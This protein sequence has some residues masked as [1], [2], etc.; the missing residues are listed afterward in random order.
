MESSAESEQPLVDETEGLKYK[1]SSKTLFEKFL[2]KS[3]LI[4]LL[5]VV[6]SLLAAFVLVIVATLDILAITYNAVKYYAASSELKMY[7]SIVPDII[8][9]IDRYLIAMVMLIFGTGLYRLF[10]S[11]I[12]EGKKLGALHPFVVNSFDQLKDKIARVVILAVF[13]EVF[14]AIVG[15]QFTT[16]EAVIMLALSV[17]CLAAALFLMSKAHH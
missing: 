6:P 10:I 14:K 4:V 8:V 5:A 1:N 13:V 15:M 9:A 17:L 11:P 16:P 2:W 3:R 7:D 12:E